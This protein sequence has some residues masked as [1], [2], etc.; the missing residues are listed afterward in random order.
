MRYGLTA[1]QR[2]KKAAQL[3][4]AYEILENEYERLVDHIK[5]RKTLKSWNLDELI[6]YEKENIKQTK[7]RIAR[8]ERMVI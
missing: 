8:L 4:R 6:A 3:D 2:E 7:E 5:A 1:K